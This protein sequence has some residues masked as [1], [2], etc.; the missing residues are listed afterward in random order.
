MASLYGVLICPG[1]RHIGRVQW[2]SGLSDKFLSARAAKLLILAGTERLDKPLTIAQMQ[3]KFQMHVYNES[4]HA[5]QE[6]EPERM[7][8]QLVEFSTRNQRLVLP[9]R[10]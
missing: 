2:F 1:Q 9:K 3:G 10:I 5:V 8:T 6:D 7:A 4:G